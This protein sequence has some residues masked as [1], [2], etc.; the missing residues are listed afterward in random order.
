MKPN[1]PILLVLVG[2]PYSGKSTFA[3]K[4]SKNGFVHVWATKIKKQK[5]WNDAQMISYIKKLISQELN[6]GKNVIF[7][8]I[9]H[10]DAIRKQLKAEAKKVNAKYQVIYF[11][12]P[13]KTIYGRQARQKIEQAGRSK[14]SRSIIRQIATEMEAPV[15][16]TT[17]SN[18][19]E[20]DVLVKTFSS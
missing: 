8:F 19:Q 9:S 7:D 5:N 13:L 16:C 12:I 3:Q 20:A 11:D 15:R 10:K 14:I 6:K 4:L 18:R 2:L 1:K 17:V